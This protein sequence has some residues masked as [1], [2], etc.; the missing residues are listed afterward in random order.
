M[1]APVVVDSPID[2]AIDWTIERVSPRR[3]LMRRH[4]RHYNRDAN[5]RELINTLMRQR[6]YRAADQSRNGNSWMGGNNSAD[7]E[8]TQDLPKLRSRSRELNRDDSIASGLTRTFKTNVIGSGIRPQCISTDPEVVKNLESV[9]N[10]RKN[11]LL[12]A[13]TGDFGSDQAMIFGKIL[14]DGDIGIK[15]SK[16]PGNPTEPLWFEAIEA[17][18]INGAGKV[19]TVPTNTIRDGV[20]KDKFGRPVGYWVMSKHPGDNVINLAQGGP[21]DVQFV[22]TAAFRLLRQV[23]RPGQTRGIPLFHAIVQD[24]R[25][26]DLLLVA[27]LKRTQVAACLAA[28]IK[29]NN[30][31]ENVLAQT[32]ERVG[33][34]LEQQLEPGMIF[35]LAPNEEVQALVPNFPVPELV[36]FVH[37]I[38]H[39]IGASI[40][41]TWQMVLKSFANANYS[42]ARTDLLEARATFV[43]LQ[44]WFIEQF[45]MPVWLWVMQDAALRGD[46]RMVGITP[47]DMR[48]VRWIPPGWRW[49]DPVKEAEAARIEL[50]IGSTT[51]RDICSAQ[52]KDWEEVARQQARERKYY[53]SLGLNPDTAAINATPTTEPDDEEDTS[54]DAET[55]SLKAPVKSL[56]SK[57]KYVVHRNPDSSVSAF[58]V[59]SA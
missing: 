13:E 39:R 2:R 11:S 45:L 16:S 58:E 22:P 34:K 31:M 44:N 10:E 32:A 46:P 21:N 41:I 55:Q 28:F 19:A 56:P 29:T 54:D 15:P 5:Y 51:R 24:L 57:K 50:A 27:S 12:P 59:I 49:V 48:Q 30:T 7:A 18:R 47:E 36:P 52:G 33:L 42:S 40:G 23:T 26:L 25:D 53:E 9:W 3:A 1:D 17:D 43:V 20:E 4:F 14:E 35:Q 38:C 37:L 8:I 6:G